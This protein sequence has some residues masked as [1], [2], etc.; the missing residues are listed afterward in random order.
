MYKK[1]VKIKKLTDIYY[2]LRLKYNTLMCH[3]LLENML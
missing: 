2:I 1:W 3:N